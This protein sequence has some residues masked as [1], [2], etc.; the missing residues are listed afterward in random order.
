MMLCALYEWY[1]IVNLRNLYS[2][3]NCFSIFQ[4]VFPFSRL[5]ADSKINFL[6]LN[7][8]KCGGMLLDLIKNTSYSIELNVQANQVDPFQ[9]RL[10]ESLSLWRYPCTN[11]LVVG[12][13]DCALVCTSG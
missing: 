9:A 8:K 12:G 1:K 2:P 10:V 11:H 6:A 4:F 3:G 7:W 13:P 5:E